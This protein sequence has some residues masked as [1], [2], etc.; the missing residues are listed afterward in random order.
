MG[1]EIFTNA[2]LTMMKWPSRW[3]CM[4]QEC[5]VIG[6]VRIDGV[7]AANVV[8]LALCQNVPLG[9]RRKR[10]PK[11]HS[12]GEDSRNAGAGM[13]AN[14]SESISLCSKQSLTDIES[15]KYYIVADERKISFNSAVFPN[16]QPRMRTIGGS[17]AS[18]SHVR[19]RFAKLVTMSLCSGGNWQIKA[20]RHSATRN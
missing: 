11:R 13:P 15:I 12:Y 10:L 9:D 18:S 4:H 8:F 20:S 19:L 7:C 14:K 17:H 16:R 5:V 1:L 2:D 3:T 6:H